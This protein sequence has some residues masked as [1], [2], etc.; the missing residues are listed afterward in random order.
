MGNYAISTLIRAKASLQN[1]FNECVKKV[2]KI[3]SSLGEVALVNLAI[4]SGEAVVVFASVAHA[5]IAGG[6]WG[7]L[8]FLMGS[9]RVSYN[10]GNRN[11]FPHNEVPPWNDNASPFFN[12]ACESSM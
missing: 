7:S 4:V 10:V 11:G 5:H 8:W 12:H 1:G 6:V 3:F 2:R 9:E